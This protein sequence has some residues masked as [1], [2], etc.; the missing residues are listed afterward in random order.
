[1]LNGEKVEIDFLV[2]KNVY[3]RDRILKI[4]LIVIMKILKILEE[5]I[6]D[7]SIFSR[8]QLLQFV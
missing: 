8:E 2:M 7:A 1:M 5:S 3:I 6:K 4:N